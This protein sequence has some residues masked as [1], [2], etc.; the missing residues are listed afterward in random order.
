MEQVLAEANGFRDIPLDGLRRLAEQGQPRSFEAGAELMRQGEVGNAMYVILRGR[1]RVERSHPD[2]TEPLALAELGPGEV[3]GEMGLLDGSPRSATVT[4]VDETETVE[5]SADVLGQVVVQYPDVS[6][7]LLRLLT[8]R[9][10]STDEL[11]DELARRR[12]ATRG[13]S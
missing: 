8:R 9:L 2:L 3:V 7:A 12:A 4:A 11:A 1:V 10:R 6:G 13:Q 5:L